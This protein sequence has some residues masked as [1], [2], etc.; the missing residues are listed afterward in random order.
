MADFYDI[1]RNNRRNVSW[2][3]CTG[4]EVRMK[5]NEAIIGYYETYMK[6]PSPHMRANIEGQIYELHCYSKVIEQ[7]KD[8]DIIRSNC[9]KKATF[10]N[11]SYSK[12]G[13]INYHSSKI[14]LAEFDILGI[15]DKEIFWWEITKSENN[16]KSL[17][18]EVSRKLELLNR[19]FTGYTVNIQLILPQRFT[20]YSNYSI[21]EIKEPN[22]ENYIN[23]KYFEITKKVESCLTLDY[24]V[25]KASMYDY[26]NDIINNSKKLFNNENIDLDH[27]EKTAL[28]ERLYDIENMSHSNFK[29]YDV[30]KKRYGDILI[31]GKNIYKDG[32]LVPGIKKTKK[33]IVQI[34]SRI[35][36]C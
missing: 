2:T 13:K 5:S 11:F 24:L 19:I 7:M 36:G 30:L 6:N 14:H 35:M 27:L 34:M 32:K 29:Y 26:I 20:T 23:N 15:K 12:F 10:G 22:Y 1:I 4:I 31:D 25:R 9:V 18:I 28:I 8:I 21:L 33:E 3:H 16:A 17:K